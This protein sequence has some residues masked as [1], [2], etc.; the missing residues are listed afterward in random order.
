MKTTAYATM[1][2]LSLGCS[3]AAI[4]VE[5][6][7]PSTATKVMLSDDTMEFLKTAASTNMLEIEASKLA[8]ERAVD[9]A[10]KTFAQQMVAD[11]AAA[12]EQLMQLA[13]SKGVT[14]P[15][16]MMTRHQ[17]M[18]DELKDE[19]TAKDFDEAYKRV[20][21]MSHKEAVSLFDEVAKDNKDPEV[22]AFAAKLLP[23]LQNHGGMAKDLKG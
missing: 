7:K 1:L 12:G 11:H 2:A 15:T 19:K 17:T 9:P 18:L 20:M 6:M 14:V 4:A 8:L 22:K 16:T 21:V 13:S 5:P 10:T 23:K 3:A